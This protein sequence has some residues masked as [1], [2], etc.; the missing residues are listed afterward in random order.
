MDRRDILKLTGA[1]VAAAAVGGVELPAARGEVIGPVAPPKLESRHDVRLVTPWRPSSPVTHELHAMARDL[2]QLTDGRLAIDVVGRGADEV[3]AN[4]DGRATMVAD[5]QWRL[6]GD[7]PAL[8]LFSGHGV[9]AV[10]GQFAAWCECGGGLSLW[11]AAAERRGR[12]PFIVAATG[13]PG[14]IWSSQWLADQGQGSGWRGER[15]SLITAKVLEAVLGPSRIDGAP[16]VEGGGLV[17][18]ADG[19]RP[20]EGLRHA[21]VGGAAPDDVV[22]ALEAPLEIWSAMDEDLRHRFEGRLAI[23]RLRLEAMFRTY[24]TVARDRMAMAAEG[25]VGAPVVADQ[26]RFRTATFR[27]LDEIARSEPLAERIVQSLKGFRR[28]T[29]GGDIHWPADVEEGGRSAPSVA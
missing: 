10:S 22:I 27:I 28:L 13:Q 5:L 19:H 8:A 11:R 18:D 29:Q 24:A 6:A 15:V 7:D 1:G 16:V 2:H 25:R 21:M 4:T 20:G 12:I 23:T 26:A 9:G 17:L 3:A 14:S